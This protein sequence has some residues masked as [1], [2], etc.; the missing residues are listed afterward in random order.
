MGHGRI[1]VIGWKS[2][3]HTL[4]SL[5]KRISDEPVMGIWLGGI[6]AGGFLRVADAERHRCKSALE[7]MDKNK[8]P[9]IMLDA[10]NSTP[11]RF[12][13]GVD[14]AP[15]GAL[16]DIEE[17]ADAAYPLGVVLD[18]KFHLCSGTA[19]EWLDQVTAWLREAEDDAMIA[20]YD[21]KL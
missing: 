1:L 12:A 14:L 5:P 13:G 19:D 21:I 8:T 4:R 16:L 7:L 2:D 6:G 17:V 9:E 18:G 20:L 3:Q 15:R 11:P 10:L